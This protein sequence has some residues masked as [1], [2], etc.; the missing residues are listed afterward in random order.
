VAILEDLSNALLVFSI[1]SL[2]TLSIA[3]LK[4]VEIVESD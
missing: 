3:F 1:S 4:S 2:N